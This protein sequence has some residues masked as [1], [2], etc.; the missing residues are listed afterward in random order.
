MSPLSN[1]AVTVRFLC[2]LRR[3]RVISIGSLS[4]FGSTLLSGAGSVRVP[5][6]CVMVM[7]SSG[8]IRVALV[9][10]FVMLWGVSSWWEG[11]MN[12]MPSWFPTTVNQYGLA[13]SLLP[14]S[15]LM[16]VSR[17]VHHSI[18]D[19]F[20]DRMF[21]GLRVLLRF[22]LPVSTGCSGACSPAVIAASPI[23]ACSLTRSVIDSGAAFS[24]SA[25]C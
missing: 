15:M 3:F 12:L 22:C 2:L 4:V 23:S 1:S 18:G 14:T 19:V 17:L 10:T 20:R 25:A 16:C 21:V 6:L 7:V 11:L 9:R 24:Q 8:S 13:A 5:W